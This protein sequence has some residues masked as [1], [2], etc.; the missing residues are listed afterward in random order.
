M[1]GTNS[2]EQYLKLYSRKYG[3]R[4]LFRFRGLRVNCLPLCNNCL[5]RVFF[6]NDKHSLV[7]M[8]HDLSK[9]PLKGLFVPAI[10]EKETYWRGEIFK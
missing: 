4:V 2:S 7:S 10:F 1:S 6:I 3:N 9:K 5:N 8:Y